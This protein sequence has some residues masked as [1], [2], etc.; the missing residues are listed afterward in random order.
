MRAEVLIVP[1]IEL[2]LQQFH[3][4]GVADNHEQLRALDAIPCGTTQYPHFENW[5]VRDDA[6]FDRNAKR[7]DDKLSD[8][9]VDRR[10]TTPTCEL[11]SKISVV[12][13]RS[14]CLKRR[15]LD[16]DAFFERIL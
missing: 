6:I 10:A 2:T 4:S 1:L 3:V 12:L 7:R 14:E 11:F 8:A 16:Q 5:L 13:V 15:L 9:V